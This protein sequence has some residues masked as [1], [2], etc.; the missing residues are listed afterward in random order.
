[1]R[2]PLGPDDG[3]NP[4]EGP[5]SIEERVFRQERNNDEES[6]QA[7]RPEVWQKAEV[8]RIKRE[9]N[10]SRPNVRKASIEGGL[11]KM[12]EIGYIDRIEEIVEMRSIVENA[13]LNGRMGSDRGYNYIGE[14]QKMEIKVHNTD[15]TN[16]LE[17]SHYPV[18]DSIAAEINDKYTDEPMLSKSSML[19]LIHTIGISTSEN[20]SNA[21]M[22]RIEISKSNFEDAISKS[23]KYIEGVSASY[24][25]EMLLEWQVNGIDDGTIDILRDLAEIMETEQKED[26]LAV[27][28]VLE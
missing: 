20:V 3:S 13:I 22:D 5:S 18:K 1:M 28:E 2:V 19:R 8:D 7:F 23:R 17:P 24:V 16:L 9:L 25:K 6:R 12:R 11:V 21:A 14:L 15:E 27:V 10:T 4:D 26:V